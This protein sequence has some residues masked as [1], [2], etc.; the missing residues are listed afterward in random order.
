M[1]HGRHRDDDAL[2]PGEYDP[3]CPMVPDYHPTPIAKTKTAA[4]VEDVAV[5]DAAVP[6]ADAA[7]LGVVEETLEPAADV[8]ALDATTAVVALDATAASEVVSDRHNTV[9]IRGHTDSHHQFVR[10][11]AN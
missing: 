6:E 4:S 1:D 5:E 3:A 8:A 9:R 7:P 10:R 11:H 2:V